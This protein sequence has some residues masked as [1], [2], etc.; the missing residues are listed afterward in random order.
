MLGLT[1]FLCRTRLFGGGA[2]EDAAHLALGEIEDDAAVDRTH[3]KVAGI[4]CFAI[5]MFGVSLTRGALRVPD[6]DAL[7]GRKRARRGCGN[8]GDRLHP[9]LFSPALIKSS[10]PLSG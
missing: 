2:K 8:V 10:V 6:L 5:D 3:D 4:A 9:D 1:L 7:S